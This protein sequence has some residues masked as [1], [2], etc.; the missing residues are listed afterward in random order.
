MPV[1]IR[2]FVDSDLETAGTILR[3][4]FQRSGDWKTDLRLYRKIQPD[5]YFLAEDHGIPVGMVGAVIYSAY[6]Y[7][8]LMAVHP[9][10]QRRGIGAALMQHVLTWLDGRGIPLVLL[11]A[12]D[13]GQSLYEKLGF[14]AG[15]Q[16]F[17]LQRQDQGPVHSH[18]AR[19]QNLSE[20]DLDRIAVP[21]AA[22]FGADR[23]GVLRALLDAYPGRALLAQDGNG[24][25]AGYIF[26][27]KNRIGPWV[28]QDPACAEA[29]LRS[30]LSLPFA[31]PIS[32]A[33][34]G[35]NAR[36][37]ELLQRHGF[38]KVRIN[39]H[40][41]RGSGAFPGQREKVFAQASLS[42]G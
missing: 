28:M 31:G 36:A 13:A 26:A 42:L 2:S 9:E 27:Q 37:I 34:P 16:V 19:T 33:V 39:L 1:S 22:A 30:A 10:S 14:A 15:E 41:A 20:R 17:I 11:D 35:T 23:G 4:A 21:D 32:A 5:G 7:V 6:A 38:E 40:M 8:G 25:V 12:S 29:L 18:S 3:L 24:E